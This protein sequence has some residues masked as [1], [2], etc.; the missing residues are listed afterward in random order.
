MK[1]HQNHLAS[2]TQSPTQL[3]SPRRGCR[4]SKTRSSCQWCPSPVHALGKSPPA[5]DA[6]PVA[7]WDG[8]CK[9]NVDATCLENIPSDI[10]WLYVHVYIYIY[11]YVYT[12]SIHIYIYIYV[13][14]YT[15]YIHSLVTNVC[16]GQTLV[17]FL[18]SFCKFAH[19]KKKWPLHEKNWP[20]HV[21]ML[22]H[23]ESARHFRLFPGCFRSFPGNFR[24]EKST[25]YCSKESKIS[26][27]GR[28]YKIDHSC[29][30][31]TISKSF[32]RN[33]P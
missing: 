18:P 32:T 4:R 21:F 27:R 22:S 5:L 25:Y 10:I 9:R 29:Q 23:V 6:H 1:S 13:S 12:V 26:P 14:I 31:M 24:P 8:R 15:V 3:P 16:P 11:I 17:W 20:L 30:K 2:T 7:R 33:P 28:K 19:F